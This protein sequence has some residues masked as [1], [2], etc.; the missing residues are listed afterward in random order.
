MN[1]SGKVAVVHAS[2]V[3][4]ECV[5]GSVDVEGDDVMVRTVSGRVRVRTSGLAAVET[6]SGTVEVTVPEGF[7]PRVRIRG[8]GSIRVD[9]PE[10]DDGEIAVRSV[11]GTVRVRS[12]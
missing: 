11:S 2:A 5:S 12:R 10:G 1:R 9:V 3:R 6:V 7:R 4:C 8:Q